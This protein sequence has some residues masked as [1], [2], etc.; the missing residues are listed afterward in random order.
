M[1]PKTLDVLL[2]GPGAV[3][4][5]GVY[6]A[7]SARIAVR[8]GA[9]AIYMTGF[10]VAGAGFGVPDIGLVSASEMSERVGVIAAASD[11]VPLI[12]DGDNGHGG[13]LNAAKLARA[14]ERA[15]AAAIQLE[16]QVFPKRC[17]HM[18]DKEVVSITEAAQKIRAAADARDSEAF[19][20]VARTDA[21]ATHGL[22]EALRRGEA[23]LKAG[24]DVLFIEAPRTEEEL[25]EVA[26][27]FKGV[28]LLANLVEDGKTPLL[29]AG[30][31]EALGYRIVLYPIS[32]LLA[33][34]RRLEEVYKL[35]LRGA[36]ADLDG[37]RASF[38]H[39]NAIMRLP[40]LLAVTR[41]LADTNKEE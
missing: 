33:V 29:S 7:L 28:P 9:K 37:Q 22:D 2:R 19:K 10:G 20:I 25:R 1:E 11:G 34:T 6:D 39:Y 32:A 24:A 5:P 3:V 18:E 4:L 26:E 31:L 14:Y 16:D 21:R 38:G 23:F 12:A 17:G 40:E 36:R 35:L 27:T 41:S 15:G 30:E 13:P 8:A